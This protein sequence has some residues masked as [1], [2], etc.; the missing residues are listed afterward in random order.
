MKVL[1]SNSWFSLAHLCRPISASPPVVVG[2]FV[3]WAGLEEE[4][5]SQVASGQR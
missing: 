3:H 5:L 1:Q 2:S 4:K